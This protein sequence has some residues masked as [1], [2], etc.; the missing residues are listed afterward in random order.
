MLELTGKSLSLKDVFDVARAGREISPLSEAVKQS[1]RASQRWVEEAILE[2]GETIYGVNTGV[3]PLAGE[4]IRPEESKLLSRKIILSCQVGVGDPLPE[5][6][7]RA[8]MLI[9]TNT[10]VK[11][12]S[13]VRPVVAQTLIDMLNAGV[14]PFVPCKGSLGASGDLAPLAHVAVVMTRDPEGAG[15]DY[16]GRAW[17]EGELLS[18]AEAMARA[19]IERIV[20]EAKDGLALTNGTNFMAAAA[21]LTL[22][23]GEN[24]VRHAEVAA[25]LSMEALTALSEALHPALHEANGQPGQ[26]VTAASLRRLLEGS[27]LVDSD[28]SRVQDA[29]SLRCT[30]QV[31]G[32]VRDVLAFLRERVIGAINSAT[33]NPLVFVDLPASRPRKAISGGNFHGSGLSMWLDLLAIALSQVGNIAERRTFRLVTP[34]LSNGLPPMLVPEPGLDS[35][36]MMPQYTSAALV[37]DN[38]TLAHPDSV[39][40]IP[41]GANQEDHVS[42]GANAARH[43]MEVAEN[44]RHIL[45]IE[46]LTAAQGIYLRPDGPERLAPATAAAYSEIRSRVAPLEHDRQLDEDIRT[47]AQLISSGDLLKAIEEGTGRALA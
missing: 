33:D 43:A 40:S 44:L 4:H 15:E 27:R 29:Y 46:L 7:A 47:L 2:R 37:S 31:I 28:L 32:P 9:R 17:F 35:G 12:R 42:M 38:K 25:A 6:V 3:G 23:D 36:L 20:P 45:A 5:D 10:L 39:D 41:S 1:M 19:G 18:G 22:M 34:E 13:A 21:A 14:T 24:L 8:M 26:T 16:S 30:P 11:G